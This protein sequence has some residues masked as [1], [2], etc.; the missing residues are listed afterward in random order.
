MDTARMTENNQAL[1]LHPILGNWDKIVM[2]A[3]CTTS[4]DP[5]ERHCSMLHKQQHIDVAGGEQHRKEGKLRNRCH[6]VHF[7]LCVQ[8]DAKPFFKIDVDSLWE[9]YFKSHVLFEH[10]LMQKKE[11]CYHISGKT[12]GSAPCDQTQP[13]VY[14]LTCGFTF[15][16]SGT[17]SLLPGMWPLSSSEHC[18][19]Q[20]PGTIVLLNLESILK[21]KMLL[22][23]LKM[24]R[25]VSRVQNLQMRQK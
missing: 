22:T 21:A 1:L 14:A 23:Q 10:I 13:L 6:T 12:T 7:F 5:Q 8:F 3:Q 25:K 24:S 20:T 17:V 16:F 4:R 11:L 2:E 9:K 15:I 18:T 19:N